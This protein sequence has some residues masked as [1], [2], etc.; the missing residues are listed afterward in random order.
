V[1]NSTYIGLW[2]IEKVWGVWNEMPVCKN[3][4]SFQKCKILIQNILLLIPSQKGKSS[5]I[6]NLFNIKHATIN[7]LILLFFSFFEEE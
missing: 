7:T 4:S 5:C 3:P 2:K 6:R 1:Y